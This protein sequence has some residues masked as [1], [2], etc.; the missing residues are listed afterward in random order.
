MLF[1]AAIDPKAQFHGLLLLACAISLGLLG[2]AM[3]VALGVARRRHWRRMQ[4]G[5]KRKTA[6]PPVDPWKEAGRRMA[7]PQADDT[8]DA[9]AEKPAEDGEI[10]P[11]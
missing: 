11:P 5:D 1:L 9:G 6:A 10:T 4:D 7:V 3:I 2:V 8:E